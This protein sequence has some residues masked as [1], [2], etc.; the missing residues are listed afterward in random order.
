VAEVAERLG[1]TRQA[2]LKRIRSR[3]LFAEK[4]GRAYVVSADALSESPVERDRLL[5]ELLRRLTEAYEPERI[6]LFGSAA[7]GD[8]DKESDYDVLLVVPDDAPPERLRARKGYEALWGL[9]AA[10]DVV[11]WRRSA[12]EASAEAPTSLPAIVLREGVLLYAA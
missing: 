1:I 11:V 12:F 2:V 8:S 3:R 6:Y 9:G 5:G 10:V 4:V 7:R